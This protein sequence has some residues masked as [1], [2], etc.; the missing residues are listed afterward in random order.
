MAAGFSA[1]NKLGNSGTAHGRDSPRMSSGPGYYRIMLGAK[2]IF[3]QK[4]REERWFGGG[5]GI[6]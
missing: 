6:E 1:G 2:S 5:W 4:C 3:A